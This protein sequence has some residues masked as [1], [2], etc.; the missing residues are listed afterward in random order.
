MFFIVKSTSPQQDLAFYRT[1]RKARLRLTLF[2]WGPTEMLMSRFLQEKYSRTLMEACIE[3]LAKAKF[4][5]NYRREIVITIP[6]KELNSIAK[7]IT[8]GTECVAGSKILKD[9][10]TIE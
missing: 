5:L 9:M 2:R 1:R 10:F 7:I 8:Y 3:I 6:D 4:N